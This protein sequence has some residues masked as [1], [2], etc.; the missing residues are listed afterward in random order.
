M[1]ISKILSI[2]ME[3][4]IQIIILSCC[5]V[6]KP[7]LS[8]SVSDSVFAGHPGHAVRR[9]RRESAEIRAESVWL[10]GK[11]H[12]YSYAD[13]DLL[14]SRK[15]FAIWIILPKLFPFSSPAV[16]PWLSTEYKCQKNIFHCM[17]P[18]Q[19][20]LYNCLSFESY[21]SSNPGFMIHCVLFLEPQAE[22]QRLSLNVG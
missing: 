14:F 5:D 15:C 12:V 4:K 3:S 22:H 9:V 1:W 13:S 11:T 21:L 6:N 16:L 18:W 19:G 8:F 10:P 17:G 20:F 2:Q 7:L